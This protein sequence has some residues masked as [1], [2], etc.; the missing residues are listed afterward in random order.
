M[1]DHLHNALA[2]FRNTMLTAVATLEFQIR[3]MPQTV[4]NTS[5]EKLVESLTQKI[6]DLENK[7]SINFD[8]LNIQPPFQNKNIIVSR[9]NTPALS[10]TIASF[11]P[12]DLELDKEDEEQEE[13]EIEVE[14]V[15]EEE[16]VE[17]EEVEVEE[18]EEEEQEEQEIQVE[19]F[20]YKG[21]TYHRDSEGTVYLDGEEVGIWNG[22]KIVLSA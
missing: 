6:Q 20:V 7:I 3:D 21:T 8:I 5:M 4:N 2:S 18:E 22:K 13:E 15:E 19:E 9:N 1:A 16:E 12:T 11:Y 17:V 10:S 14:E